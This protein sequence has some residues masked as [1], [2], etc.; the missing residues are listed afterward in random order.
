MSPARWRMAAALI[1]NLWMAALLC[2]GLAVA[3][4]GM[5]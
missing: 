3:L 5:P 1:P 4:M 2:L